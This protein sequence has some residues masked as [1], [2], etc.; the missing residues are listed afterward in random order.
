MVAMETRLVTVS[1]DRELLVFAVMSDDSEVGEDGEG[2][3]GEGVQS[4][5]K[6]KG[7]EREKEMKVGFNKSC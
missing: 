5:G 7:R 3:D 1:S 2:G 4:R 6:R